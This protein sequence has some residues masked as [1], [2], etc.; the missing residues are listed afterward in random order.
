M[1]VLAKGLLSI[2][3]ITEA[4][5]QQ[6]LQE[7][8]EQNVSLD[9]IVRKKFDATTIARAYAN[10]LQAPYIAV[11]NDTNANPALL[12][13]VPFKFLKDND[14]IPI[15]EQ[16]KTV[17]V[18]HNPSNIGPL[19]E[20]QLLFGPVTLGISTQAIISDAIN[21]YYPLEGTK[22]ALEELGQQEE[23]P[24]GVIDFGLLDEKDILGMANEAPIIKLVNSII[25]QAVKKGASDIH[26][27]PYEKEV[28][29]RYRIDGIMHATAMP[30]KRIQGAL[31]SRIKIMASM[32]IA[33]KRKPQDGRIAI[34]I[35]DKAIDIRVSILPVAFGE[36]VVMRLLDKSKTFGALTTLGFSSR[37]FQIMMQ[38]IESPNGIVLLTGPT[39]S[40]KTS[41][42]YAIL[43]KLNTPEVSI[44]TVEDPVEYQMNGISQ[45]QV[46]EKVGLTFATAL[47]SILRQDPDIIM[48][49]ETRDF[50]TAQIAIQASLTGHLVLSTLHTNSAPATVTRLIDMGIEPFLI[51]S[52]LSCVIAQRLVRKLCP[53]CKQ[54]YSPT[55]AELASLGITSNKP[56]TFYKPI[57]CAEC[58]DGYRGRLAIFEVMRMTPELAQMTML[59]SDTGTITKAAIADGMTTLLADGIQKIES[60]LTSVAEVLTVATT[61]DELA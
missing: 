45:V 59:R 56:L 28:H 34:K 52:T 20:L 50:E 54:P 18:T 24:E 35:A 46:N 49:G 3:A 53:L 8:E 51:A 6:M 43:S 10:A 16:G 38:A 32:N 11:I 4:E 19:D 33:E 29:V 14:I 13:R 22:Q 40:G 27:E 23:L 1:T 25:F 57:G 60:G 12:G 9:T 2:K 58:S 39:G 48:V 30:P 31:I 61:L 41:T 37:D 42:L 5:L 21:K 47:R 17:L 7:A 26:I 15:V 36:K 55:K 44:V